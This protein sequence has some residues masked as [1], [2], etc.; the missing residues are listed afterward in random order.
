MSKKRSSRSRRQQ[1]I[2]QARLRAPASPQGAVASRLTE[3]DLTEGWSPLPQVRIRQ[4]RSEDLDAV[5]ALSRLAG[6]DI[7][8]ELLDAVRAGIAGTELCAGLRD[9]SK[10]G[11]LRAMAGRFAQYQGSEQRYLFAHTAL[12]LVAENDSQVVIG[13]LVAY[14]PVNVVGQLLEYNQHVGGGDQQ[15]MQILMMGVS[16]I[17]RVKSLAV[18]PQSR[19]QGVGAALL[20]YCH[21]VYKHL[22]YKIVYG[23]V[24]N[25]AGLDDFYRRQGFDVLE[26]GVGF[27]PWVIVGIHADIRPNPQERIFIWHRPADD[28]GRR[29]GPRPRRPMKATGPSRYDPGTLTLH[30]DRLAALLQPQ[31]PADVLV[32]HL[33]AYLW[34]KLAEGN[35]ANTCVSACM[36]LH[37]AYA[38]LGIT[39]DVVPTG[40]IVHDAAGERAQFATDRPHW[41]SETVL[42]GHTVLLLPEHD[43]LVDPTIEQVPSIRE[44]GL[45]RVLPILYRWIVNDVPVVRRG[46][47]TDEAW[48][49]ITPLLPVPGTRFGR[50]RDHRQVINGILWKLRTGAPWRD[51]PERYGPWKTCHERLRRWT[52]N[53]TWDRILA[54]AQVHDDGI[55]VQWTI[56]VDS[57]VVRAHQHAA[58][59]RKKGAPQLVRRHRVRKMVRPSAGHA[60]G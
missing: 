21:Q 20:G 10:D 60:G 48:A 57:S 25:V 54:A 4:A 35:P 51:L 5:V 43:R 38:Q 30:E 42:V 46:E 29:P 9:G 17:C 39:A 37:H 28:R 1:P 41:R 52:A 44:L 26:V 12:V 33:P 15:A 3:S 14:P 36:T 7:E 23:Q 11:F 40:L 32:T 49:V 8:V 58:G 18:A 53:G 45:G 31:V 2:P 19:G 47:L 24:P 27:D 22:G 50:W 34:V 16:A 13:A 56:S 55:P 6:V 59:A